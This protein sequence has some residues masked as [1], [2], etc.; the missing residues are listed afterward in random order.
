MGLQLSRD[1][2]LA[3]TPN[4]STTFTLGGT[5]RID[6]RAKGNPVALEMRRLMSPWSPP[7][8]VDT[9]DF[10]SISGLAQAYPP[11]GVEEFRL[12]NGTA[13]KAAVATVRAFN[14]H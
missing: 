7:I 1:I 4:D 2:A 5:D 3:D 10:E 12:Y 13:G 8:I 6:V 9:D 11:N 14:V